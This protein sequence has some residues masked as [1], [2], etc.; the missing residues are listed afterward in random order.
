[1]EYGDMPTLNV[2][3]PDDLKKRMDK[4]GDRV[5]WSA[6]AQE[7]FQHELAK[8]ATRQKGPKMNEV[9]ERLK[10]SKQQ[11][12]KRW[13][14]RGFAAGRDWAQRHAEYEQLVEL[15]DFP[16]FKTATRLLHAWDREE[17]IV[18]WALLGLPVEA[19]SSTI[20]DEMV[21]GFVEGALEVF[22]E[23]KDQL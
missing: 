7:A 16:D 2:Y 10:Q 8:D 23:V 12:V 17:R 4:A 6:A 18:L 1:M 14:E 19:Q 5:N 20:P 15:E 21:E 9:A 22:N 11:T 13:H 3:V